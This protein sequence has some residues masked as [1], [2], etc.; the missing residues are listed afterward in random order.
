MR[1]RLLVPPLA[2][3]TVTALMTGCG[4]G[5]APLAGPSPGTPTSSTPSSS[6]P[7][8]NPSSSVSGAPVPST[9]SPGSPTPGEDLTLPPT[10][11]QITVTGVVTEG[12]E[13]SCVLLRS[14]GKSYQLIGGPKSG[15]D[16]G[17]Q[18]EVVGV[19]APE[20]RSTCQ[21][22]VLLRVVSF[23]LTS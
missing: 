13:P 3:V 10:G 7:P 4:T 6:A 23:R 19:L 9:P 20:L 11:K 16:Y 2:L 12:V 18:V 14:E 22:G 17:Q 1:L 5:S 15:A 8:S 21:Q